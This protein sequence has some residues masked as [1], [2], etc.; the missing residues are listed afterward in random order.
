MK[1]SLK[2]KALL[3]TAGILVLVVLG[4]STVAF[5]LANFSSDQ[6]GN[7]LGS[8]AMAWFIYILYSVVLSRLEYQESLKKI[9]EKKD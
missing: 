5:I 6:I 8:I 1:L 4:A 7:L 9:T 2:Q 3:T